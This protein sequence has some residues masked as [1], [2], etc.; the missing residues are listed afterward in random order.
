MV[1]AFWAAILSLSFVSNSAFAGG[2]V[3]STQE[4]YLFDQLT[5]DYTEVSPSKAESLDASFNSYDYIYYVDS[6][7]K[8]APKPVDLD[9]DVST[10][11]TELQ[12]LLNSSNVYT[13]LKPIARD[14]ASIT[15]L[16]SELFLRHWAA[17]RLVTNGYLRAA[18]SESASLMMTYS[19]LIRL[20]EV[21]LEPD[22]RKV[23]LEF[24]ARKSLKFVRDNLG[25]LSR[26]QK[27]R[28]RNH[29]AELNEQASDPKTFLA[30]KIKEI[31]N[32]DFYRNAGLFF[33]ALVFVFL[34]IDFMMGM[35][36]PDYITLP[37]WANF[38]LSMGLMIPFT[39]FGA[40]ETARGIAPFLYGWSVYSRDNSLLKNLILK[41]AQG[42]RGVRE[43]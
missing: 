25:A 17:A 27:E 22:V 34:P 10:T 16:V 36:W 23:V 19:H 8:V 12:T 6:F 33:L 29:F 31:R 26:G 35:A 40:R 9:S 28:L 39:F 37:A 3:Y 4:G 42:L 13:L 24:L 38:I 41:C 5:S 1:R 32:K 15:Q 43:P 18:Q 21:R 30:T 2:Y 20:L 11:L 7:K 14:P